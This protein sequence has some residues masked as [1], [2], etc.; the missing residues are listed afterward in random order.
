MPLAGSRYRLYTRPPFEQRAGFHSRR[1]TSS[2]HTRSDAAQIQDPRRTTGSLSVQRHEVSRG[3]KQIL[4]PHRV[5]GKQTGLSK[6]LICS[7]VNAIYRIE[8]KDSIFDFYPKT[9]T[10]CCQ[11]FIRPPSD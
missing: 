8:M 7:N 9:F 3:F 11:L 10:C 6:I 1:T 5:T 2:W 4:I